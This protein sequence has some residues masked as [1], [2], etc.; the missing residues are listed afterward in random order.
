MW[1]ENRMYAGNV[2]IIAISKIYE[3][4]VSVHFL[5]ED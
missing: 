3:M 4:A 2:K 5:S 1:E